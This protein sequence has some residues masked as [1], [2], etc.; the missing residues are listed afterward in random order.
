MA[1]P[2]QAIARFHSGARGELTAELALEVLRAHLKARRVATS[3]PPQT[4]RARPSNGAVRYGT[5]HGSRW[6]GRFLPAPN[7]PRSTVVGH[8][9]QL[10]LYVSR[11]GLEPGTGLTC[12]G[13]SSRF[14]ST[15]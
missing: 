10:R 1:A 7:A 6:T 14:L 11:P 4:C 2:D 3:F 15:C 8:E 9:G 12:A 5:A 13:A